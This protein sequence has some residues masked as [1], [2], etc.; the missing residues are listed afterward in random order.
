MSA[1]ATVAGGSGAAR[2]RTAVILYYRDE[3]AVGDIAR[4]LG[5]TTGTIKT[6]L[7]RARRHFRGRLE[8][9]TLHTRD[10]D[11][12]CAHVLDLIDASP[13]ADYPSA[14]LDAAWQH[15]RHCATCGPALDAATALAGD[16]ARASKAGAAGGSQWVRPRMDRG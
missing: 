12:T 13:L 8:A 4:A 7:F 16:L 6:L 2:E 5:V 10:I 11:M 15:A 3:M 1:A 14:R 9:A